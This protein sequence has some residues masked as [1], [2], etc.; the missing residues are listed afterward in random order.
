[1]KAT[2]TDIVDLDLRHLPQ[3]AGYLLDH[4]VEQFVRTLLRNSYDADVPLL[5]MLPDMTED[6]LFDFALV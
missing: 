4:R 3:Y 1:M 5:R 6:Q 2:K